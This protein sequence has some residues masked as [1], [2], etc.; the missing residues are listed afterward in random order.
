MLTTPVTPTETAEQ[1]AKD[2]YKE[3]VHKYAR[4]RKVLERVTKQGY[5]LVWGQCSRPMWEN[6]KTVNKYATLSTKEDVIEFCAIKST[7]FQAR[8]M[9]NIMYFKKFK[10]LIKVAEE[11]GVN[12][13]LH[14]GLLNKEASNPDNPIEEEIELT[15]GKFFELHNGLTQGWNG[16]P[17]TVDQA[18]TMICKCQD[19]GT[20]KIQN[21]PQ[22]AFHADGG[23]GDEDDQ[24]VV[25]PAG[26]GKVR[27]WTKYNKCE[28]RTLCQQ[29]TDG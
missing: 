10:N 8:D 3:E 11:H 13:E 18:Y 17:N 28:K 6:F 27:P 20:P 2:I 22:L 16:H 9:S 29:V 19:S 15:K 23:G 12:L 5:T 14:T 25:S 4:E 24:E 26:G 7:F 1:L 21:E